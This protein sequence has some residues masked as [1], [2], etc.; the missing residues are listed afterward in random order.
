MDFEQLT[1][2]REP[3]WHVT[4]GDQRY[5]GR[6][7]IVLNREASIDWLDLSAAELA[8]LQAI[9]QRM[10]AALDA[11]FQPDIY[12]HATL[13]NAWAQQH[14]HLI[15]RYK[16]PRQFA[17]HDFIDPRWGR[18]PFGPEPDLELPEAVLLHIRDALK[19]K[20]I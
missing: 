10:R 9:G 16:T 8:A 5:L 19:S 11:L 4:L 13:R 20:I 1:I 18:N 14:W 3:L 17:G 15:P 12:N 7:A 2:L 6:I